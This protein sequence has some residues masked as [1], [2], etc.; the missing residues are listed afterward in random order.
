MLSS[1]ALALAGASVHAAPLPVYKDPGAPLES[2]V[3][4]LFGKLT[5]DEKLS[6]LTGTDFSARP[7]PRLDLPPLGMVDAGQG[8]RG[9]LSSTQGPATAFPAG[10]LLASSWDPDLTRRV[11]K[12]IAEEALNKGDGAQVLL[13][14]GI[15]IHRSPLNGRNGEYFSEDPYLAGQ[16]AAGYIQGVQ[17]TG[18]AA[19]V[20]HFACNNEEA[21]RGTVDVH[22]DERTL[23]EIYLP[24][25]QAAVQQGHVWSIMT[26]YNKVNGYHSTANW[27]LVSD[28]LK[29]GWGFD[30]LVMSDWGAVHEVVG[31]V[32]AGN[33]LEMPGPG[34]ITHD[35]LASALDAGLIHQESIDDSVKRLIR[36]A[37]R[38]GL[39][40]GP[41]TPDHSAVNSVPHQETALAAAS[42]GMVL[43]KNEGHV[44]P[45]GRMADRRRRQPGRHA[46]LQCDA[47]SRHPLASRAVGRDQLC[48]GRRHVRRTGAVHGAHSRAWRGRR[49]R[50]ERRVL[51][52]YRFERRSLQDPRRSPHPVPLDRTGASG[53]HPARAVQRPLD[54]QADRPGHRDVY[55]RAGGRRWMPP[56]P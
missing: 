37:I 47:A 54:R 4:D 8:V 1:L 21:D 13:A 34:Q 52:E 43:L 18:V 19:C 42:Q 9:G 5:Q 28:I 56:L 16:L 26:S 32:N 3:N 29:Q 41:K 27:Y 48:A 51:Q 15:N 33:D 14:P 2:R 38:T 10:V 20:K 55:V 40:D 50:S 22:V 39:L 23:R 35:A 44:L 11:G 24:A 49:T 45:L 17:S 7:V 12:A 36:T 31:V 6:L 30:G 25:F 46:V 53:R